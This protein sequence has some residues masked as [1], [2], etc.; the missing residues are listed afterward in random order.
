MGGRVASG[1]RKV[2]PPCARGEAA[3]GRG[4]GRG[5]SRPDH[6]RGLVTCVRGPPQAAF[7]RAAR[8]ARTRRLLSS[9]PVAF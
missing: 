4:P 1:E 2:L 9:A 8:G 5:V 3:G 7:P 6:T